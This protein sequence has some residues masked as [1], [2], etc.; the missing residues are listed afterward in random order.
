M[1]VVGLPADTQQISPA[2]NLLSNRSAG[3]DSLQ[4]RSLDSL[5]HVSIG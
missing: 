3:L 1:Q 2:P 4:R 5:D